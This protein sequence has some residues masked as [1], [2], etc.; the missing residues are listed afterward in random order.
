[1]SG[2]FPRVRDRGAPARHMVLMLCGLIVL[3]PVAWIA[4]AA[5]KR[6]IVLLTGEFLFTPTLINF[7]DV[8]SPTISDYR[9]NF[10]NSLVIGLGSTLLALLLTTPAA[11]ALRHLRCPRWVGYGLLGWAILFHTLPP[12]ILAGGWYVIFR[13]IGLDNTYAGL[14]C[15]HAAL[16]LPTALALT[17][18]FVGD[19]PGEL[20]EAARLDG[21][22]PAQ[23]LWRIVVPLARPGL[24][25]AGLLSFIFSWNEFA[26]TLTLSQRQTA[27]VPIAIG[28]YAQENTINFTDM[29][30]ASVLAII[31]ALLVLLVAQRLIVSGL[32]AGALK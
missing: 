23:M 16:G 31:P 19:V 20:L 25:A 28:K 13:E 10:I 5:F 30:A 29:A 6:Q 26:V 3:F 15:A 18:V 32:T 14:I 7:N 9:Q 12:I 21:A 24:A 27:T 2:V 17:M 4:A 1:M 8:L 11:F 22:T